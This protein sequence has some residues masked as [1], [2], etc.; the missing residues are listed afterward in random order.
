MPCI[1]YWVISESEFV[2]FWRGMSSVSGSREM[3]TPAAGVGGFGATPPWRGGGGGHPLAGDDDA[4]R[5]RGGI[6]GHALELAGEVDHTLDA[7][8]AVVLLAQER[9]ALER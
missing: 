3:T 9:R 4:G 5:V 8:V 6:A 7:R 2:A 1:S